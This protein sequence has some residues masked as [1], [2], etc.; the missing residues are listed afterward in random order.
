MKS[1]SPDKPEP[2]SPNPHAGRDD[3]PPGAVLREHVYDGIE[4]YDQRLPNWWLWT[5][6]ITIIFSFGYWFL[7]FTSRALPT[8]S[9][10][11]AAEMQRIEALR[12]EQMG[13]VDAETLWQMSRNE[14]ILAQG[15]RVYAV[16][17]AV[18]HGANLE[19][20][21]GQA[22]NDGEWRWG[23]D[24][25]DIHSVVEFGSPDPMAGMQAWG[26]QLGPRQ[27]AAVVAYVLSHNDPG[28]MFTAA[29]SPGR[30]SER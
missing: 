18:C 13:T 24:P 30:A 2:G 9:E 6:Y 14:T 19:G 4:E 11:V 25:M 29:D 28:N 21:I 20:G 5:L 15:A 8:D 17:C 7:F 1:D 16:N 12:F 26:R 23:H 3:I 27:V 22:L 10:R